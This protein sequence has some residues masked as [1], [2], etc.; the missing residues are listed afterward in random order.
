MIKRKL[1]RFLAEDDGGGSGGGSTVAQILGAPGGEAK[2]PN[3]GA[4]PEGDTD[5]VDP[6]PPP[7]SGFNAKEFAQEFGAVLGQHLKPVPGEARSERKLPPTP[8]EMAEARKSLKFWEPDDDFIAKFGNLESQKQ[9]FVAMRDGLMGQFVA[10]AQAMQQDQAQHWDSRFSPVQQ[11]IEQRQEQERETR[12]NDSFPQLKVPE[13]RPMLVAITQK[14]HEAGEFKGLSETAAFQKIAS[15]MEKTA[16]AINPAFKLESKAAPVKKS[17]PSSRTIPVTT[18]GGG[19]GG[20]GGAA[21]TTTGVPK[22]VSLL[23]KIKN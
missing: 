16:Q 1:M 17:T 10:I 3:D 7:T 22:A 18:N 20:G 13:L 15:A 4:D 11:M 14:L 23:P 8:E 12:F 2:D 19:G 5:E 6:T 21:T 9:A